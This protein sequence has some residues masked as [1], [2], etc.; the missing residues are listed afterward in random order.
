MSDDV[1]VAYVAGAFGLGG[2]IVGSLLSYLNAF[3]EHRRTEAAERQK[4]SDEEYAILHG[5][6]ALTNFINARIN[7]FEEDKNPFNLA[8]LSVAQS[9]MA[10]LIDKMPKDNSRLMVSLVGLSLRLEAVVFVLGAHI[11]AG[12]DFEGFPISALEVA[13]SELHT[14]LDLVE[15][16]LATELPISSIEELVEAGIVQELPSGT[17]LED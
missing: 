1:F 7:E 17:P 3:F 5:A 8:R 9:H 6:F 10:A 13:L 12:S 16:L 11:G 14:E 2:V 15:L 4:A